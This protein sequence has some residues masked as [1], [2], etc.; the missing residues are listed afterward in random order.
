MATKVHLSQIYGF[1][2]SHVWMWVLDHK[3]AECWRIDVFE[4][5]YW[6]RLLKVPWTARSN[7]LIL[8]EISP[9]YIHWRDWCWSWSFNTFATWC[10]ELTHWKRPRCWEGLKAGGEGDDK[11]WDGWM[12]SA[13]QWTSVWINST[14][15][16]WTGR[17]D[18]LHSM[19]LQSRTCLSDW[20]ELNWTSRL[21]PCPSYCEQCW[22]EHWGTWVSF[23]FGFLSVD[24]NGIAGLWQL[25]F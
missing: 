12:P 5:W 9:E 3:E 24:S 19:G 13:T 20:T 22:N 15:L 7:Q 6:R 25:Y 16:L 23:N 18:M 21:L 14:S 4:L 1:S 10:K 17:P 11:E 2:S 8:K